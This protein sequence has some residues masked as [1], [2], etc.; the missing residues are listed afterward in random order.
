MTI[1]ILYGCALVGIIAMFILFVGFL[2]EEEE[3]MLG[4]MNEVKV[5][6][7]DGKLKKIIT[8]KELKFNHWQRFNS[9]TKFGEQKKNRMY[10]AKEEV[11]IAE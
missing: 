8:P 5:Y 6:D 10:P 7:G 1:E 11:S 4:G 3:K 9:S 2:N